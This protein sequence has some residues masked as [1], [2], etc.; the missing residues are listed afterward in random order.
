[1]LRRRRSAGR[2]PQ[3]A[4]Q[5]TGQA[6]D[7]LPADR[8]A[9]E[10]LYRRAVALD[11]DLQAAWFDL[12]LIYKW[13]HQWEKAYECNER[14]AA[15]SSEHEDPAW[16][17]L[18]IAA[19]ALRRWDTARTAWRAYGLTVPDGH[20]PIEADFGMGVVRLN[21]ADKGEV[22]WGR[23]IDPARVRVISVPFPQSG[24][25]WADVVLHDGEPNGER[26]WQGRTFPVFDELERWEGSDVP[27]VEASVQGDVEALLAELSSAGHAAENWTQSV[28]LLCRRCSEGSA[29]EHSGPSPAGDGG[30]HFLGIAGPVDQVEPVVHAWAAASS[31]RAVHWVEAAG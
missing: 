26:E 1:V 21:P 31:D 23:R 22:V 7:L 30:D 15:L 24:H 18:G 2:D 12:G 9:A 3:R 28:R 19:T 11:P 5:L 4:R 27:T 13:S 29:H 8:P 10:L 6:A 16:W 20:G 14:A 25:R 17:N